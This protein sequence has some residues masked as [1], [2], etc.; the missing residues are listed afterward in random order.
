MLNYD[1]SGLILNAIN[2]NVTSKYRIY[3]KANREMVGLLFR[4]GVSLKKEGLDFTDW[5]SF[6]AE[7]FSNW[8]SVMI[9][10]KIFRLE[11]IKSQM[12]SGRHFDANHMSMIWV[13]Y[14]LKSRKIWLTGSAEYEI[15][16]TETIKMVLDRGADPNSGMGDAWQYFLKAI[17]GVTFLC[18]TVLLRKQGTVYSN[19]SRHFC[20]GVRTDIV[21]YSILETRRN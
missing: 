4:K 20:A 19:A 12:K 17:Y 2:P 14:L 11:T 10:E 3:D 18:S 1:P 13:E 8:D 21:S 9:D 7:V 16:L 15:A 5:N 6:L